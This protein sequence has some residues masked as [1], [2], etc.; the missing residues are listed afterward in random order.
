M[1]L[2]KC[3]EVIH[4]NFFKKFTLG[5]NGPFSPKFGPKTAYLCILGPALRIYLKF[6]MMMRLPKHNEMMHMNFP[7][8]IMFSPNGPFFPKFGS[9]TADLCIFGSALRIF[10]KF[11]TMMRLNKYNKMILRDFSKKFTFGANWAFSQ[12]LWLKTGHPIGSPLRNF[13][14]FCMMMKLPKYNKMIHMNFPN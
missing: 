13:L 8:K 10:F 7:K 14:K 5:P 2:P 6:G 1:R 9:K 3:N 4:M 12:N 11:G